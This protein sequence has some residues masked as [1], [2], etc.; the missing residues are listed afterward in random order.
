MEIKGASFLY[1]LATLMGVL[2]GFSVS[3]DQP[4]T[5]PNWL[6]G[7]FIPGDT[8]YGKVPDGT[9]ALTITPNQLSFAEATDGP[10][11]T[12]VYDIVVSNADFIVL[13]TH[14]DQTVCL[15]GD[16]SVR[17]LRIDRNVCRT[18]NQARCED[19]HRDPSSPW[20]TYAFILTSFDNAEDASAAMP[21][22]LKE[23]HLAKGA[24][25]R[26]SF[27]ASQH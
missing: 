3:A 7:K 18:S 11:R 15:R 12:L 14:G 26:E 4:I 9:C 27:Y 22:E 24:K 8:A 21:T 19:Y 16:L 23:M 17:Y 6:S 5:T 25:W 1:T 10:V 20:H 2:A 13:K